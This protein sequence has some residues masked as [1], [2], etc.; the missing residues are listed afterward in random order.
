MTAQVD[1][2]SALLQ[3]LGAGDVQPVLAEIDNDIVMRLP[4]LGFMA[5][6]R[7][8]VAE[9]L[10]QT[11]GQFPFPASCTWLSTGPSSWFSMTW[12]A[13]LAGPCTRARDSWS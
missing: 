1:K 7:A 5:R 9:Q 3:S 10:Q 6:G 8:A 11:A 12:P 4:S 13:G 2:V